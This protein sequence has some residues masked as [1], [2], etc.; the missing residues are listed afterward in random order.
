MEFLVKTKSKIK[1]LIENEI[2]YFENGL[3]AYEHL[4]Q[5]F[6]IF[7]IDIEDNILVLELSTIVENN[8]W[9]EE[10]KKQFG[11]EPSFF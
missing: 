10:Y 11:E 8:E 6:M 9:Q 7:S 1:C 3:E 4:H 2:V 5:K